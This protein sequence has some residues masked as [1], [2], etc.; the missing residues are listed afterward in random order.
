MA[1]DQINQD[2]ITL[3]L[4]EGGPNVGTDFINPFGQRNVGSTGAHLQVV[5]LSYG[6]FGSSQ[7]VT[8]ATP[9]PVAIYGLNPA[10]ESLPVGGDTQGGPVVVTGTFGIGNVNVTFEAVSGDIRS[11]A[12]GVTFGVMNESGTTLDISGSSVVISSVTL[13][14]GTTFGTI[15]IAAGF[16]LGSFT[17]STGIKIKNFGGFTTN[18]GGI[19]AV[20]NADRHAS[21]VTGDY[22]MLQV[23]E[24]IFIE[25]DNVN[26]LIFR[27]F[28]DVSGNDAILSYQAS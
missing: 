14:T 21:A 15:N 6:D 8:A 16:S 3:N 22:Y 26:R 18:G 4:G 10:H 20:S 9:Y 25:I 11:V 27:N 2:N 12:P 23:G 13:P 5:K 28:S 7:L 1:G 17:C 24:E 19:L